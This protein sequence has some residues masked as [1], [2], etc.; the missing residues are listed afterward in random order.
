MVRKSVNLSQKAIDKIEAYRKE[1]KTIPSFSEVLDT[2]ILDSG[3]L[4]R[5][6]KITEEKT[7]V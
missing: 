5:E 4:V 6:K 7:Y 2:L 3:S 1:C